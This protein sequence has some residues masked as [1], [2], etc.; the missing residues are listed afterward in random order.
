MVVPI[1]MA[2]EPYPVE[3]LAV[4]GEDDDAGAAARAV[5]VD[6]VEAYLSSSELFNGV[7]PVYEVEPHI[8]SAAVYVNCPLVV[9]D[10][11]GVYT[12]AYAL[13]SEDIGAVLYELRILHS[14]RIHRDLVGSRAKSLA[15]VV[16]SLDTTSDC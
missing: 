3:L 2:V 15:D 12:D 4:R 7:Y 5:G 13:A 10:L 9:G 14:L 11:L 8:Y 6:G 16:N 1:V